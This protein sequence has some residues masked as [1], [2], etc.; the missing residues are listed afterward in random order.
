MSRFKIFFGFADSSP[1]G[2]DRNDKRSRVMIT[3][4]EMPQRV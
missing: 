2:R 1:A 3:Q 4:G